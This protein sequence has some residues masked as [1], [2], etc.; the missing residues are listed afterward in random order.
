RRLVRLARPH[1][2][3]GQASLGRRGTRLPATGHHRSLESME[4]NIIGKI[5]RD[6]IRIDRINWPQAPVL[7]V[8]HDIDRSYEYQGRWYAPLVSTIEDDL[9]REGLASVSVA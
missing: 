6:A 1:A 7:T 8:A 2:L 9:A 4:L 5:L 3:A